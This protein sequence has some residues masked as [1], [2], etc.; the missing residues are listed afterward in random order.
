M[1][2]S[3]IDYFI[4]LLVFYSILDLIV[5]WKNSEIYIKVIVTIQI[6]TFI[7]FMIAN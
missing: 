3:S 1:N 4:S 5:M 7:R 2:V 6:C